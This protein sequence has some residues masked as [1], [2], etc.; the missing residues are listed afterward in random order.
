MKGRAHINL[1]ATIEGDDLEAAADE[2][3]KKLEEAGYKA[4]ELEEIEE[5]DVGT[6]DEED[7][8]EASETPED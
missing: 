5:A 3:V 6:D 4:V 8:D 1:I 7:G 2:A